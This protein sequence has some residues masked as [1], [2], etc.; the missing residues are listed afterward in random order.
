MRRIV[1]AGQPRLPGVPGGGLL[2]TSRYSAALAGPWEGCQ[3]EQAGKRNQVLNG[4][5]VLKKEAVAGKI[6]QMDYNFRTRGNFL[7]FLLTTTEEILY[8]H[9][10]YIE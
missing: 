3:E 7:L 5:V 1:A 10:C 8:L 9:Y 6:R 2:R 4:V